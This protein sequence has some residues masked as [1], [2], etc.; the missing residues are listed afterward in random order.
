MIKYLIILLVITLVAALYA[1]DIKVSRE[2]ITA[3]RP[4]RGIATGLLILSIIAF[5]FDKSI[6]SYTDGYT[7]GMQDTDEF[8]RKELQDKK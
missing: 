6:K 5:Q 7:D 2:G 8:Y 3:M 4:F 1:C